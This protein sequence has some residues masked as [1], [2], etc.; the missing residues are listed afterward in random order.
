MSGGLSKKHN[1]FALLVQ[2]CTN[3]HQALDGAKTSKTEEKRMKNQTNRNRLVCFIVGL[4]ETWVEQALVLVERIKRPSQMPDS[5]RQVMV[6]WILS[7]III[8]AGWAIINTG[9]CPNCKRLLGPGNS[10]LHLA[11]CRNC[12]IL[13]YA[14][15]DLP[16]PHKI[17]CGHCGGFYYDCPDGSSEADAHGIAHCAICGL[18]FRKCTAGKVPHKTILYPPH[19]PTIDKPR[20]NPR[21]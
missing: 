4:A 14:C 7:A 19:T 18:P 20:S 1:N 6:A 2:I 11:T 3:Q 15:P 13:V 17:R 9:H 21:P 5:I 10:G 8:G 16:H 12:D